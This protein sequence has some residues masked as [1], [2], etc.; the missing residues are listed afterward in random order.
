MIETTKEATI[1]TGNNINLFRLLSMK[2]AIKLE[3]KG[4]RNSRGSVVAL[5]KK[6][7]GFKGSKEKVLEQLEKRIQK[8]QCPDCGNG[9]W[10]KNSQC[11][12]CYKNY[13]GTYYGSLNDE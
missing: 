8:L 9:E 1:I 2:N 3:I 7:F 13:L 6:E 5:C 4:L 10:G 11:D 12:E